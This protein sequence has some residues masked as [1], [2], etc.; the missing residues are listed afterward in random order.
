MALSDRLMD[1]ATRTKNLEDAAAATK[2]RNR[3]KLEQ[4]REALHSKMTTEAKGIQSSA[5]KAE[6]DARS[7]W[8][9]TTVRFEQRRAE[10]RTK[11]D[12]QRTERKVERAKNNAD[13][14]EDYASD[15]VTWAAYAIDAAEYAVI[16]AAIAR[17]EADELV[18]AGR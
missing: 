16:D 5:G 11:M 12:E 8:N 17:S 1:L 4:Q 14:A 15:M 13:D 10:L 2:A 9:D 3:A 6:A 18:A 7:W